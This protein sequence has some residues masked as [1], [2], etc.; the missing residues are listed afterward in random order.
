MGSNLTTPPRRTTD[1]FQGSGSGSPAPPS[2]PYSTDSYYMDP[3]PEGDPNN[4]NNWWN[5]GTP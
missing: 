4:N 3:E 1:G 5:T 2:D